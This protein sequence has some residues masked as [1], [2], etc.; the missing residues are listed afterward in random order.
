[1]ASIPAVQGHGYIVA[2]AAQWGKGYPSD[3][4]GSTLDNQ[5]FG[6]IDGQKYGYG[7]NGSV[8]IFKAKFPSTKGTLSALIAKNQKLYNNKVDPECGLTIYK[9]SARSAL[10]AQIEFTGFMHAGPCEVWCDNT[11]LLFDYDCQTKYPAL[12]A[13]IPYDKSK[14]ANANRLTLYWVA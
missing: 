1:M 14:C 13:K 6:K 3:G 8:N 11:K 5:I 7:P 10:P 12:P 4:Y 9:D 2:P